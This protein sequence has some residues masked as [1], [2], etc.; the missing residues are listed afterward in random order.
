[1]RLDI[2]C[3]PSTRMTCSLPLRASVIV[4]PSGVRACPRVSHGFID[5]ASRPLLSHRWFAALS[6]HGGASGAVG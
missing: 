5:R 1:M 6:R 2:R 4:A 3:W